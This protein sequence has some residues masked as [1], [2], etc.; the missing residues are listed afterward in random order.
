MIL[1]S[2]QIS[3]TLYG[4]KSN[5]KIYANLFGNGKM[6]NIV[7]DRISNIAERVPFTMCGEIA[8]VTFQA[9]QKMV[10]WHKKLLLFF[11]LEM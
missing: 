5:Y 7:C 3:A 8:G 2:K 10:G 6:K 1:Y 4:M 9:S 11:L